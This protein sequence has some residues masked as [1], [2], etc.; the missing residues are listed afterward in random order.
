MVTVGIDIGSVGTKAVLFDSAIVD[1]CLEPTGWSPSE[2]GRRVFEKIL[3]NNALL[4]SEVDRVITT[5]YGRKALEISD[6]AV[7]E[8]TCHAVGAHFLDPRVRTVLD[9][10]GQ[11]SKV[12]SLDESGNVSDFIM[13]DKCA[14]GTGRFLQV[15]ATLL[16]YELSELG[17]VPDDVEP[18]KISS[19]CTVFAESEVIGL[20][21]RGADKKSVARGLLESVAD[22]AVSMLGKVG[23]RPLVA[24]T[25]GVSRCTSLV[26]IIERRLGH[27]VRTFPESQFAGAIGAAVIGTSTGGI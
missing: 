3:D 8:I 17:S 1:Y 13:N 12:I 24:F 27:S 2:A 25:G 16:E 9:I 26:P 5:G 18:Q 15:M 10:G 7:T 4:E 23:T 20:L 6:R 22:R 21:A 19:M 14:A 11:D